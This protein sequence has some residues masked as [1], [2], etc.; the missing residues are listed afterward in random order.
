MEAVYGACKCLRLNIESAVGD[1]I[2]L[3]MHLSFISFIDS[4]GSGAKV[5]LSTAHVHKYSM[6]DGLLVQDSRLAKENEALPPSVLLLWLAEVQAQRLSS[7][8]SVFQPGTH[9]GESAALPQD[10]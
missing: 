10:S 7:D 8:L 3:G 9:S 4:L 1:V 2:E 6:W 5:S